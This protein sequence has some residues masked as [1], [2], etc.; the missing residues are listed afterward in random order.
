LCAAFA[1]VLIVLRPWD[2]FL[3]RSPVLQ[4]CIWLGTISYSLYLIHQFN[5]QLATT[6]GAP[7]TGGNPRLALPAAVA[8]QLA[9]AAAFWYVCERP[10]LNR[11]VTSAVGGRPSTAAAASPTT[12]EIGGGVTR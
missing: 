9:L 10:F 8:A 2:D 6:V 1:G 5:L 7:V 3:S 4:P 11:P 12:A